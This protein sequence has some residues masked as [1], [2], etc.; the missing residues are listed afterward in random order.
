MTLTIKIEFT[1]QSNLRLASRFVSTFNSTIA[2]QGC[3]QSQN[4]TLI[5]HGWMEGVTT[6]WVANMVSN[7]LIHRGGC[8]FFMDYSKFANVTDYFTLTPHF[9]GI[10]AVLTK[11]MQQIGNYN[12]QLCF[13]FSFGS[14][15]C[16]GAG[17]TIARTNVTNQII[18]PLIGRSINLKV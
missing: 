7:F 18:T 12:R 11:K 14:R 8:L 13:G 3:D 16:I 9:V 10:T 1:F 6:P 4:I 5:A 17:K 2:A 15:V